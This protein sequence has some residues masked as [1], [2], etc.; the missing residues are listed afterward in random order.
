MH[1]CMLHA[2]SP[3]RQHCADPALLL[4][5]MTSIC[6]CAQGAGGAQM[7]PEAAQEQEEVR[8]QQEERRSAMLTQV[9]QP[10][11]RERCAHAAPL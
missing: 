8:Q 2:S 7:G 4:G 5:A 1:A 10:Q 9:L 6:L 3:S 11:A